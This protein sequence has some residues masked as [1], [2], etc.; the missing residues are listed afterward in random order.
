[1]QLFTDKIDC[2]RNIELGSLY[3]LKCNT[4]N[5]FG[6]NDLV[7]QRNDVEFFKRDKFTE[8]TVEKE[9][10]I[11]S[12]QLRA[13]GDILVGK[14]QTTQ[15]PVVVVYRDFKI[16]DA[17]SVMRFYAGNSSS[18]NLQLTNTDITLGRVA[19]CD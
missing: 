9:A 17:D 5:S 4:I 6:D 1:M 12:K 11:R 16:P 3:Q 8:D 14:L 2:R 13:N 19:T 10:I 18:A 7:F 15:T